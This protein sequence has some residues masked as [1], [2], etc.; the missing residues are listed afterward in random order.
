VVVM[1]V[2]GMGGMCH[3]CLSYV[4]SVIG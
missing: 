4:V 2:F 3:G 1:D